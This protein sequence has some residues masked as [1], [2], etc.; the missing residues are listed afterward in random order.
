MS[1]TQPVPVTPTGAPVTSGN[2]AV[3]VAKGGAEFVALV[4]QA[5]PAL[6]SQLVG[7]LATYSKSVAAPLVGAGVGLLVA[8]LGVANIVTPDLQAL[9]TEALVA[10]GTAVG[11]AVMHWV[12][13]APGRLL[14]DAPPVPP[15]VVGG[16]S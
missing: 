14:Q 6:Y 5:D 10:L 7:S 12:G 9:L 13:K 15:A 8:K 3:A 4:Q 16:T 2:V 1:A 11:A